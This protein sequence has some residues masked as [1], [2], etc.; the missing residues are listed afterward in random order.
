M[1]FG[2]QYYQK[3]L[4]PEAEKWHLDCNK[5]SPKIAKTRTEKWHLDCN[6]AK[7]C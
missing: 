6:T 5:K 1:T 7:N 2:L 3:L 4:K